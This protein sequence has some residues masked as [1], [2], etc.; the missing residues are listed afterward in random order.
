[1][2]TITQEHT[3]YK[4]NELS[5]ASKERVKYESWL[6]F[7]QEFITEELQE[8]GKQLLLD[9]FPCA[10][11]DG[12]EYD[13]SY[14]Q[15][16][17]A[18]IKFGY[19]ELD[20]FLRDFLCAKKYLENKEHDLENTDLEDIDFQFTCKCG[21]RSIYSVLDWNIQGFDETT[22]RIEED[23]DEYIYLERSGELG[24]IIEDMQ[25]DF[26]KQAYDFTD[27]LFNNEEQFE[28]NWYLVD[29]TF[30]GTDEDF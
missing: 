17:G 24:S 25:R 11:F 12:I 7:P 1:M 27:K 2:K 15:G 20:A 10:T 28:E 16:S 9:Y 19:N 23:L 26:T 5:D 22:E 3:I 18:V 30:M 4:F 21:N 6:T 8:L 13:L 29:G 14:T